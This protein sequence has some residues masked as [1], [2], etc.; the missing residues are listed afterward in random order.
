MQRT[1]IAEPCNSNIYTDFKSDANKH[2][3][4]PRYIIQVSYRVNS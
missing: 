1:G 3:L 4:I 2:V